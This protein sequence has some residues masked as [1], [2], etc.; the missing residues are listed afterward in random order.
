MIEFISQPWPWYV[1]G[2]LIALV[3]AVMLLFGR[4]FGFSSNLRTVCAACGAGKKFNFFDFN[5]KSQSWNLLFALGAVM[6]GFLAKQFLSNGQAVAISNET[7]SSLQMLGVAIEEQAMVPLSLFSFEKL[8]SLQGFIL[9]VLGGFFIGFGARWAG[10]CTS[11]HAIS[12]LSNLQF[13]SLIAVVGFFIG[14]LFS[15][16]L[17]LPIILKL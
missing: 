1:G 6:G 14:G 7:V 15:T 5:W 4:N 12:G 8:L 16:H 3:M 9:M 17:L 11:G 10:G 13:P 2:P